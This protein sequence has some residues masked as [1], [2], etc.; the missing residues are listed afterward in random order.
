MNERIEPLFPPRPDCP[1]QWERA[2]LEPR[3][4][5]FVCRKCFAVRGPDE[6]VRVNEHGNVIDYGPQFGEDDDG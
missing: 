6:I 3:E 5:W 1:H 2:L 4:R